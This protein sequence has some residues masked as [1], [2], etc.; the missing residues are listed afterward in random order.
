MNPTEIKTKSPAEIQ[1]E[2]KD[3]HKEILRR[4]QDQV[5]KG[6]STLSLEGQLFELAFIAV[7]VFGITLYD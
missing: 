6:K 5:D 2:L 1:A 4:I 7:R 3:R